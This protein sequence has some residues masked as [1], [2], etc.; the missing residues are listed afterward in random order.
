MERSRGP[1]SP[2]PAYHDR[3][4]RVLFIFAA[5]IAMAVLL[6]P[7]VPLPRHLFWALAVAVAL[8]LAFT[9]RAAPGL[10]RGRGAFLCDS[11][12][13]DDARYCRR[14]ERPNA[15]SCPDYRRAGG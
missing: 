4:P 14:P 15:T 13:Y 3:V 10:S 5:V 9:M 11:C 7:F 1:H 2:H 8:V 12:K 6:Q